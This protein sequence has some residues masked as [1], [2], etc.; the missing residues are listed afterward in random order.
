MLRGK[1][2]LPLSGQRDDCIEWDHEE[3]TVNQ[4]NFLELMWFHVETDEVL[5]K[6]LTNS[7]TLLKTVF[8]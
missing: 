5:C 4:G 7:L 1:Q 6:Y 8:E 3:D 2:E